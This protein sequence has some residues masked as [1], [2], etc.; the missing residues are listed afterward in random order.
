M[1]N[2]THTGRGREVLDEMTKKIEQTFKAFDVAIKIVKAID[3][4][5]HY[6]F[7]LKTLK[8]VRMR[9]IELF[10]PDLRYAL[11]SDKIVIQ[12]PMPD[13][14]LIGITVPKKNVVPMLPWSKVVA[15]EEFSEVGDLVVPI[16]QNEFGEEWYSDIRRMPHLLIGGSTG[17]GKSMLLDSIINSLIL[18]HGS[19]RLRFIFVDPKRWGLVQYNE[20]PHLLTPVITDAK[21]VIIALKWC[22]K[23]MERRLDIFQEYLCQNISSYHETVYENPKHKKSKPEPLPY[24]VVIIDELSDLMAC[25]PKELESSIVRLVQMSRM[26]GIYLILSTQRPSVNVVTGLMKAN[27]PS[28]IAFQV[29]SQIDSRT[30]LDQNGAEKLLGNGDMLYLSLESVYPMRIQGYY[31]SQEDILKNIK[32]V[33]KKHGTE[34]D[35]ETLILDPFHQVGDIVYVDGEDDLYEDIKNEVIRAGKASTSFIQRKF[36]IGY[37]RAAGLMD[38]LEEQGIIGPAEGS[39]PRKV[40]GDDKK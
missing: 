26:V 37:S 21:K 19:E 2:D 23:E 35:R 24:I 13:E 10:E 16:G 34:K 36:R 15:S 32:N 39:T 5:R 1:K 12:A 30:I 27:I 31:I 20:I 38:M 29:T 7:H 33:I 14:A 40:I 3:G 11:S 4:L 8:P 28:R 17:S 18:K 9:T 25:Y 22:I 6:H